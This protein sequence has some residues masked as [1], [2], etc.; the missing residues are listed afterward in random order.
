MDRFELHFGIFFDKRLANRRSNDLR[1]ALTFLPRRR[2]RLTRHEVYRRTHDPRGFLLESHT[3]K[4]ARETRACDS[5]KFKD[6]SKKTITRRWNDRARDTTCRRRDS[7]WRR[8]KTIFRRS[9][10]PAKINDKSDNERGSDRVSYDRFDLASIRIE[11]ILSPRGPWTADACVRTCRH[12]E[13]VSWMFGNALQP[14][15]TSQELGLP[16]VSFAG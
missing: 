15:G 1:I 14:R 7:K 2:F 16:L 3:M 5:T 13:V 6:S 9:K 4:H 11:R 12:L 10:L 8:G